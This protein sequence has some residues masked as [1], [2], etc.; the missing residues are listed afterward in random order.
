MTLGGDEQFE[1]DIVFD[2]ASAIPAQADL[3]IYMG[4][5]LQVTPQIG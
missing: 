5:F 3:E 2:D 4:A 1:L